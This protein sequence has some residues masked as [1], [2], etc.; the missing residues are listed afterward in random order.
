MVRKPDKFVRL[1]VRAL[2]ALGELT[3]NRG[4]TGLAD[5]ARTIPNPVG[6]RVAARQGADG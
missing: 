2:R 1:Q 5:L 3:R 6:A 4:L